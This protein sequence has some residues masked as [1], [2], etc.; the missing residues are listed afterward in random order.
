MGK[1]LETAISIFKY[2][3]A[4]FMMLA[5]VLT[6]IGPLTPMDGALG[7]IYST[8]ISLVTFGIIFF[9]SGAALLYGKIKRCRKWT[10]WGLMAI[11][12]CFTFATLLN[13]IAFGVA[14]SEWLGNAIGMVVV[15][16]LWL[17]WRFKTEYIN[18]NHFAKDIYKLQN[19]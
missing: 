16:A 5:G 11:Y 12:C 17:R 2:L 14:P 1:I 18:P 13:F 7:L 8:R 9:L 19:P 6:A 4:L 10:G 15:G 3:L